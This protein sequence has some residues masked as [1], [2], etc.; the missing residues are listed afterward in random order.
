MTRDHCS[1]CGLCWRNCHFMACGYRTKGSGPL[2]HPFFMC[3]KASFP[4]FLSLMAL[5]SGAREEWWAISLAPIIFK[6]KILTLSTQE[7]FLSPV[8]KLGYSQ[9]ERWNHPTQEKCQGWQGCSENGGSYTHPA[10]GPHR[11]TGGPHLHVT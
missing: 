3:Q 4:S 5:L 7:T 1:T 8:S 6:R 2:M 11:W 9:T 10:A